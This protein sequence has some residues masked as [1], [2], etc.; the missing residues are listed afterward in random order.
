MSDF[1]IK[2]IYKT[3][4]PDDVK[5]LIEKA[6]NRWLEIVIGGYEPFEE[7][8]GTYW[9]RLVIDVSIG[10]IDA[11]DLKLAVGGVTILNPN[12]LRPLRSKLVLDEFEFPDLR[13][14]PDFLYDVI[15][16]EF[17]HAIGIDRFLWDLHKI[18]KVQPNGN[19]VL[20]GKFCR[21]EYQSFTGRTNPID[22]PLF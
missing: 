18:Y 4:V 6:Q 7:E 9:D 20:N 13:K 14:N 8:D 19:P 2:L 16:H 10:A 21:K 1:K 5:K 3:H 22:L 12:S 15:L 11:G 17:G